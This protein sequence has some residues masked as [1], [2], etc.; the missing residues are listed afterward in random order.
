MMALSRK[1]E[2]DERWFCLLASNDSVVGFR[3]FYA[4]A[5]YSFSYRIFAAL[6]IVG[7]TWLESFRFSYTWLRLYASKILRESTPR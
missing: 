4:L 1:Y 6:D 7:L 2:D 3:S 5:S